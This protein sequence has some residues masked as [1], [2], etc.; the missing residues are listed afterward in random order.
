MIRR[1]KCL[2]LMFG[3]ILLVL[4][5]SGC[6]Q[7]GA[8]PEA[9]IT[10]GR[11]ILAEDHASGLAGVSLLIVDGTSS[12]TETE[13]EGYFE[14]AAFNNTVIVPRK[15]GYNFVPERQAVGEVQ[16]LE[17]VA[18]PWREPDFAKWGTQFSF[19]AHLDRV[20]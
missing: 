2:S 16:E 1:S 8:G 3:L 10:S 11:V 20:E 19:D 12:Y 7:S 5:L 9:S 13:A 6:D 4:S 15:T 17:F 14:I 18:Y